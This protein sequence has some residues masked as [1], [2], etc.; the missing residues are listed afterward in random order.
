MQHHLPAAATLAALFTLTACAG[1]Q[2]AKPGG[3]SAR[4]DVPVTGAHWTVESLTVDG[5]KTAAP[6]PTAYVEFA[7]KGAK[8][9]AKGN[10]G[11]NHFTAVATVQGETVTVGEVS[12]TEMA[13]E[14]PVQGFEDAF[15]ETFEGR[16]TA[17]VADDRLTLTAADGDTIVLAE[18]P[19]APL[20]GTKWTVDSLV[21]G[22][23]A[24]SLPAGTEGRAH[25]T[26]GSDGSVHGSL[27][28]NTFSSTVKT[29]G[30]KLTFGRISMTRRM[31]TPPQMKLEQA[32]YGTLGN[33]PVTF[34]IDNRT[35]TVTAPFGS[36]FAAQAEEK[37]TAK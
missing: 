5:R 32:L 2:G 22:E 14:E 31:C 25:L 12:M 21:S 20:V 15:R 27:G 24:T 9:Q 30:D 8:N 19:P 11:C 29:E 35:L 28:C 3:G 13:C 16:L 6:T 37:K 7:P 1:E 10:F 17:R 23:T 26:I 18:Q 4:P 36:G 33:G 34:R